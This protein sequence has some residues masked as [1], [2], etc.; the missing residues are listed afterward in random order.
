MRSVMHSGFAHPAA[1]GCMSNC[2]A[3]GRAPC[4]RMTRRR[5]PP[6]GR[7]LYRLVSH[8]LTRRSGAKDQRLKGL[9]DERIVFLDGAM[10]TMI[11]QQQAG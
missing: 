8:L 6:R 1:G 2:C 10:G 5:A 11:Q 4:T 7:P 3:H 9:L